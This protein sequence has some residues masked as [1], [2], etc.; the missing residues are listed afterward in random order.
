MP[1]ATN[2]FT[3][4]P[5]LFTLNF[6]VFGFRIAREVFLE[7]QERRTWLLLTDW[8]NLFCM[9]FVVAFCVVLPLRSHSFPTVSRVVLG[10]GYVLIAFT[11]LAMAG[12]YRLFSAGGRSKYIDRDNPE[13]DYPWVTDQEGFVVAFAALAAAAAAYFIARA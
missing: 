2:P 3:L 10:I 1:D 5:A 4:V 8:L 11:P 13:S 7:E 9:L 6:A 12:H